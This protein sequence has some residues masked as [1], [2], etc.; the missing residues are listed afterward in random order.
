MKTYRDKRIFSGFDKCKHTFSDEKDI[1]KDAEEQI[2]P[3]GFRY[4]VD[5]NGIIYWLGRKRNHENSQK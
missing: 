1:P 2:T 5:R 4:K 3:D